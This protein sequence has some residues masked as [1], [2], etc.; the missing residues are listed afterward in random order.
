MWV[1]PLLSL[2]DYSY[3][4]RWCSQGMRS[5]RGRRGSRSYGIK[6]LRGMRFS[7]FRSTTF[8]VSA[9]LPV[10]VA[11]LDEAI[12]VVAGEKEKK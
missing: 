1:P 6:M 12:V 7:Y 2:F 10:A 3:Y 11:V 4:R 5:R 9:K 8:L